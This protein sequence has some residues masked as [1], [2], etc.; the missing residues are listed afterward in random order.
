MIVVVERTQKS[1][2]KRTRTTRRMPHNRSFVALDEHHRIS[3]WLSSLWEMERASALAASCILQSERRASCGPRLSDCC[4][5]VVD[6]RTRKSSTKRTR[7]RR[8]PHNR[9]VASDVSLTHPLVC[10]TIEVQS[11]A[12]SIGYVCHHGG[13]EDGRVYR[14]NCLGKQFAYGYRYR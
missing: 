14:A 3:A 4:L 1:S 8:R 10:L 13:S 9:Y 7:T 11:A 5:I 2:T 12:W 6:D